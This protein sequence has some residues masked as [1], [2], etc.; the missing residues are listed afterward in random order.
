[1][2]KSP[3]RWRRRAGRAALVLAAVA[4]AW[5][6][7]AIHP[8]PLFAFSLRRANVT[9]HARAPLPPE[10]GPMLDEAVRRLARS[11]LYDPARVH[12]VFL[13]DTPALFAL[14]ALWDR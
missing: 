8:Q 5:L 7:L 1:M 12:H 13:C 10:A 3:R 6:T 14:F 2:E 4:A 9:L 11:P